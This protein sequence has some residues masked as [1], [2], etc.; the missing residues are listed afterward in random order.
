LSLA[1]SGADSLPGDSQYGHVMAIH[2][3]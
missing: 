3:D 2:A 1:K